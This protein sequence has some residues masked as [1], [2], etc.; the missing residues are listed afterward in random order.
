MCCNA[1]NNRENRSRI[2]DLKPTLTALHFPTEDL[3][4][5][6][7]SP[8][9]LL[10]FQWMRPYLKRRLDHPTGT[11]PSRLRKVSRSSWLAILVI[12]VGAAIYTS[13]RYEVADHQ[14]LQIPPRSFHGYPAIASKSN[15]IGIEIESLSGQS[16]D[17]Y[18]ME[19]TEFDL[20]KRYLVHGKDSNREVV[21]LHRESNVK[22]VE[23]YHFPLKVG[24]YTFVMDHTS[25]DG[26]ADNQPLM[27]D[28]KVL[29][30][31]GPF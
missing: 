14:T 31:T 3:R 6:L 29:R 22:E 9:K 5:E 27:L 24:D 26:D 11:E 15:L 12:I 21:Y 25:F 28:F 13:P 1:S 10:S 4:Q 18:I 8:T 23:L 19:T 17:F 7:K 20:L 2:V 30:K 16:F